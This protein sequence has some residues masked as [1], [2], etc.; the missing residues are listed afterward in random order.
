MPQITYRVVLFLLSAAHMLMLSTLGGALAN[1][2]C[3][4]IKS[5]EAAADYYKSVKEPIQK[6]GTR[7]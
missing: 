5:F 1:A 7:N 4:T 3:D 6:I 2:T